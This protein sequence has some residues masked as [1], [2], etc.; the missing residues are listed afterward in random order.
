[1][2]KITRNKT[3]REKAASKLA[4]EMLRAYT[5]VTAPPEAESPKELQRLVDASRIP[6]KVGST[7]IAERENPDD[8]YQKPVYRAENDFNFSPEGPEEG[9]TGLGLAQHPTL[10]Q[11][12]G[13]PATRLAKHYEKQKR[14]LERESKSRKEK[15]ALLLEQ[16]LKNK[17]ELKL[18]QRA[19]PKLGNTPRYRSTPLPRPPGF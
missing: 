4:S 15:E 3:E 7:S 12:D 10:P 18:K 5:D 14:K 13:M 9:G 1:M 17:P 11:R 6:I 16:A 2:S 8:L 19:A